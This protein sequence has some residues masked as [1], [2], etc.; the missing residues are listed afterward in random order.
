MTGNDSA[1]PPGGDTADPPRQGGGLLR[2]LRGVLGRRPRNGEHIRD[3]I[4][5]LI[6]DESEEDTGGREER[7]LIRNILRTHDRTVSDVM[8]PRADIVAVEDSAGL[9]EV[10]ALVTG[11]SH[12]RIPVYRGSLDDALGLVHIKDLVDHVGPGSDAFRLENIIRTLLFVAPSMRV[13]DLLVEMRVTRQHMALVVD[14]YGGIDGM[15]TIEDLVEE[16]VGEIEDEHDTVEGPRLVD[17][18]DRSVIADA[19]ATIEEFEERYGLVLEEEER[20]EV[21]TLG[22]LVFA[23]AGR[24]PARGELIRHPS[25]LEFEVLD[26]DRRRIR[27]L[28][29]RGL[30]AISGR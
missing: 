17:E 16:I 1:P 18:P 27:R 4:G 6:E 14:E 19:R 25:G 8:V 11:T 12:S 2:M 13:L 22:G 23:L 9:E 10:L 5:E 3:A 28:R 21:D 15:V 24:V 30:P 29:L 26:A 20:G 7:Q